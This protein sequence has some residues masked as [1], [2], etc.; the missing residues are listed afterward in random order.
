MVRFWWVAGGV[1]LVALIGLAVAFCRPGGRPAVLG[2]AEPVEAEL[3]MF[4][5][6][7]GAGLP[8]LAT[9]LR[10]RT[11]ARAA[12]A[13]FALSRLNDEFAEG[14]EER[15]YRREAVLV[16][17]FQSG[18]TSAKGARLYLHGA[19]FD[20]KLTDTETWQ[21]CEAPFGNLVVFAVD[22]TKVP[23]NIT[24][25]GAR[26][27]RPDDPSPA[28]L[29]EFAKLRKRPEGSVR[30]AEV[31]QPDQLDA[32]VTTLPAP[33]AAT[34]AV[35]DDR[36]PADRRFAFVVPGCRATTAIF[37]LTETR[38]AAEPIGEAPGRCDAPE[39]YLAI[40]DIEAPYVPPKAEI[41]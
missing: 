40:F 34:F 10:S 17:S 21:E 19:D 7:G 26:T 18:C 4:H 16:F 31:S 37:T 38:V 14:V 41:G 27:G 32:F 36:S 25:S 8:R 11:D 1:A 3:I 28:R 13:W 5:Q 12:S 29:V 9:V 30:A 22:R 6:S 2:G 35:D 33:D 39:H 23:E 24:L 20:V 15:D